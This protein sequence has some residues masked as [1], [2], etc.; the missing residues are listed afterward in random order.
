MEKEL[1]NP[2][3]KL[4]KGIAIELKVIL[5]LRECIEAILIAKPRPILI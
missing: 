2:H 4:L 1:N 5:F 3:P